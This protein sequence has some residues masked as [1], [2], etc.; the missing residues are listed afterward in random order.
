MLRLQ[1]GMI[2]LT[3]GLGDS[4][5]GH[6][7]LSSISRTTLFQ[8]AITIRDATVLVATGFAAD[9]SGTPN[10]LLHT[11][12]SNAHSTHGLP[13]VTVTIIKSRRPSYRLRIG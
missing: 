5:L 1:I 3:A 10:V 8:K 12:R 9:Y 13:H 11:F 2:S 4:Q 7:E 6:S